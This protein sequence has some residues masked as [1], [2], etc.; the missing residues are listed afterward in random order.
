MSGRGHR[1]ASPLYDT[2]EEAVEDVYISIKDNLDGCPYA[3]LGHSMGSLIAFELCHRI[4]S[5]GG[6]EPDYLIVSGRWA[7][8]VI[9]K[10]PIDYNMSD[11]ELKM[12]MIGLGGT[13][14]G[15]FKDSQF[16]NTA[17][18]I[19]RADIKI[20]ES[21]KYIER[22]SRINSG[23]IAMTGIRDVSVSHNDLLEWQKH[24]CSTF[25][26]FK[27]KGGHFFINDSMEKVVS[28]INSQLSI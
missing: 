5:I 27:F 13:D 25:N 4:R 14:E 22:D 15:L 8:N 18:S 6:K 1:Y 26:I 3:V 24:T 19:L 17:I 28:S 11:E 21:Y 2:F 7:P 9:R 12:A 20:T 16:M 23:I 10:N